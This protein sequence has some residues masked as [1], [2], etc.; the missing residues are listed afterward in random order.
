M[1]D[2]LERPGAKRTYERSES[3]SLPR[4]TVPISELRYLKLPRLEKSTAWL[5]IGVKDAT[6]YRKGPLSKTLKI[7]TTLGPLALVGCSVTSLNCG[8]DGV[9]S[10]VSLETDQEITTQNARVLAEICSFKEEQNNAT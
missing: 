6:S 9:S 8:V 4:A 7:L 1:S 3:V 2:R 5:Y 10:Y